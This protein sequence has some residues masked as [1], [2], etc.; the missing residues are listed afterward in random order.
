MPEVPNWP[1]P[2]RGKE[3]GSFGEVDAAKPTPMVKIE[4]AAL[5]RPPELAGNFEV[6][7]VKEWPSKRI[8]EQARGLKIFGFSDIAARLDEIIAEREAG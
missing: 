8:R 7:F 4:T 6:S 3:Q 5:P 2:A 1:C